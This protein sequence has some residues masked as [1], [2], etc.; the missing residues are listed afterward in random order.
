MVFS[1]MTRKNVVGMQSTVG[2]VNQWLK[3]NGPSFNFCRASNK[4]SCFLRFKSCS[5]IEFDI[6]R[7][8]AIALESPN[9]QEH[10]LCITDLAKPVKGS[11]S[12]KREENNDEA[13]TRNYPRRRVFQRSRLTLH[14]HCHHQHRHHG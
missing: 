12:A 6:S 11:F 10:G 5:I 8:N 4:A 2:N 1:L 7:S 13:Y 9:Y 3:M 14:R